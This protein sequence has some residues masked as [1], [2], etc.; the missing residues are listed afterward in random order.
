MQEIHEEFLINLEHRLM[1]EI[2]IRYMVYGER[3][4][5]WLQPMYLIPMWNIIE[6]ITSFKQ[7]FDELNVIYPSADIYRQP[8]DISNLFPDSMISIVEEEFIFK[9]EKVTVKYRRI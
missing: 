6:K 1:F 8:Q 7:Y 9:G 2:E 5:Q 4:N 3:D